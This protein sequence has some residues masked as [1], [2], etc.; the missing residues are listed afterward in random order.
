MAELL[1]MRTTYTR[2]DPAVDPTLP[3]AGDVVVVCP[4][5]W[6]WSAE[7]QAHPRWSLHRFPKV[8]LADAVGLAAPGTVAP[9]AGQLAPHRHYGLDLAHPVFSAD[10]AAVT[11]AE[12]LAAR[13]TRAAAQDPR[14]IG[15]A[16]PKT[17][18]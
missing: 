8:A 14:H 18:G 2:G 10:P 1:V 6:K 9:N 17:V 5:G 4:D 11:A 15:P 3:Q 12:L 16:A 7:E 13:V